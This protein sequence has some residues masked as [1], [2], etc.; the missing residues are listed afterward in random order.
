MSSRIVVE[1]WWTAA[2][3]STLVI[4]IASRSTTTAPKPRARRVPTFIFA[5]MTYPFGRGR[6]RSACGASRSSR[7]DGL[8]CG[9]GGLQ[10]LGG[11]AELADLVERQRAVD[12]EQQ[13]EPALDLAD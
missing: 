11:I 6:R 8:K 9:G 7:R 12:V 1:V 2:R 4:E 3:R 10:R 13:H 5:N